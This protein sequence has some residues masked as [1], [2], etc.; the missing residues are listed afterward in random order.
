MAR[1][2]ADLER[3]LGRLAFVIGKKQQEAQ[4][5]VLA[6]QE[7]Q[8]KAYEVATEIEKTGGRT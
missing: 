5:L 8:K 4:A 1:E 2:L 3:E 7:L 6:L